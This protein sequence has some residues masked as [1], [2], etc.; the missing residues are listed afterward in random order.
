MVLY[1][2]FNTA[3]K[4]H[5]HSLKRF[6]SVDT[7]AARSIVSPQKKSKLV[8]LGSLLYPAYSHQ[9]GWDHPL[10]FTWAMELVL[11]DSHYI[12]P[13]NKTKG[14]SLLISTFLTR[15]LILFRSKGTQELGLLLR[16]LETTVSEFGTGIDELDF[17]RLQMLAAGVLQQ[18][19]T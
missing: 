10:S 9:M 14:S 15:N 3:I 16:S 18:G 1:R 12:N 19:L 7:N 2:G 5:I 11:E 17:D 4:H 13:N 6:L 8:F